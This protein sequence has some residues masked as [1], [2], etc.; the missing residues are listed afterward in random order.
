MDNNF[1]KVIV[2]NKIHMQT[3]KNLCYMV[4]LLRLIVDFAQNP[5][6][7]LQM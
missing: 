2:A 7:C 3:K 1:S 4:M 5:G 6:F